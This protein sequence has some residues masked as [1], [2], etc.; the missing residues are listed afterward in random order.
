MAELRSHGRR[1]DQPHEYDAILYL[2]FGGPEGPDEVLPFMENVTRGRGIPR[3]RLIE[4]SE[5]YQLFGG[6]SPINAQNRAV[7][8]A[9]RE[10]LDVEGP[11]LPVYWGNRN[12]HPYVTDAVRQM[13]EDGVR[14]AVAFATSAWSSYSGCRQYR[15]DIARAIDEVGE[16]APEIDKVRHFFDHPGFIG[17]Q[18]LRV[19]TAL[20]AIPEERRAGAHLAFSAH[21]IPI[22]MAEVSS[23]EAQLEEACRLVAE[24]VGRDHPWELVWQS[25]S[26]PPSVPWL[27]PDIGDHLATLH[28]K[29]VTDVVVVPIG[30]VSDHLEVQFDLDVEAAEI[31]T[32]LGINMVRA[33]A[34]GAHPDY[35]RM[36]RDLVVE[37]MEAAPERPS[38]SPIG[39]SH[40]ICDPDCCRYR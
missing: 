37:R 21:S 9:L 29:G 4:V 24:E 7:I 31:A 11:H 2:S 39:P 22:A 13:K 12:W 40:D 27:E 32:D 5:H 30:F 35:V 3:E 34:V 19:T 8:A 25:R 16:G 17:P 6:V 10:L 28:D 20:A 38:L 23:Y 33:G 26:G 1:D 14:R 15:E 36:I 18:A